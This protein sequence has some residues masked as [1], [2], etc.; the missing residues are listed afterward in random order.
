VTSD[1]M[2]AACGAVGACVGVADARRR[3]VRHLPAA[4]G[5]AP[6]DAT[7]H[8]TSARKDEKD[9]MSLKP[10]ASVMPSA[11]SVTTFR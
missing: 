1:H 11:V 3:C 2:P 4:R 9:V 10:I 7:T 8:S 5:G 6:Q